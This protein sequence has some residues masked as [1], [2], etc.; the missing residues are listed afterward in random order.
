MSRS[1]NAVASRNRRKKLLKDARG[2]RGSRSKLIR[3][4]SDALDKAGV[5]AYVGR[6]Q[7]KR[8]YRRLWTVRINNACRLQDI[9]YSQF[10]HGLKE[11]GVDLNRKILADLAVNDLPA[12]T[13]LI[14]KVKTLKKK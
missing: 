8:Q 11:I 9:N 4:V 10:I 12:F 13:E 6:K 5:H 1:I 7:K 14:N 3:T 2:F